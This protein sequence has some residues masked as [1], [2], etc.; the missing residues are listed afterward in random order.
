[1]SIKRRC[2]QNDFTLIELLVVI[3]II[4]ILASMLL[5][6]LSKARERAKQSKCQ[7]SLKQLAMTMSIYNSQCN[8][9]NVPLKVTGPTDVWTTNALFAKLSGVDHDA[10]Y[11]N[12]W[13][14]NFLC[15]SVGYAGFSTGNWSTKA[16]LGGVYGMTYW[17]ASWIGSG[18]D[19]GSWLE[20]RV[21]KMSK[22]KHA[23]TQLLFTE[24][25]FYTKSAMATP[26]YKD[27]RTYWWIYGEN[28]TAYSTAFRHGGNRIVNVAFF[29]GHAASWN[30]ERVMKSNSDPWYPYK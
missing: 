19:T 6:S 5:P 30:A 3:A 16:D 17:G 26:S 14:K 27:P 18:A 12:I 28:D 2:H 9:Y 11:N 8:D 25:S 7:N 29:D 4:A 24:V 10:V 1:M 21:T 13:D 15:P 20:T 22:V 23:S